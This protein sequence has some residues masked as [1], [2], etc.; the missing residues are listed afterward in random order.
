MGKYILHCLVLIISLSNAASPLDSQDVSK[1][2]P[3]DQL[4]PS[5]L[6]SIALPEAAY[7]DRYTVAVFNSNGLWANLS[8]PIDSDILLDG[9]K[10]QF[11]YINNGVLNANRVE[12]ST[13]TEVKPQEEWFGECKVDLLFYVRECGW[14]KV[15]GFHLL[16]LVDTTDN[17]PAGKALCFVYKR[18]IRA[19]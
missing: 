12:L 1:N 8:A 4:S 3:S 17:T 13:L 18:S 19:V 5:N 14:Q 6:T 15:L 7:N 9:A 16:E 2:S 11:F 10:V